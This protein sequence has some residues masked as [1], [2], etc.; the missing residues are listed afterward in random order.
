MPSRRTRTVPP[1]KG[2]LS[3]TPWPFSWG[4]PRERV[5]CSSSTRVGHTGAL[6][7]SLR[8]QAREQV[9]FLAAWQAVHRRHADCNLLVAERAERRG[10]GAADAPPPL[11]AARWMLNTLRYEYCRSCS[12]CSHSARWCCS[13]RASSSSMPTRASPASRARRCCSMR[14][15]ARTTPL[16]TRTTVSRR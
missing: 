3:P 13:R 2:T 11:A 16:P 1:S 9:V 15:R 14:P 10:A 5:G 6:H 8:S 4:E 7:C 12:F